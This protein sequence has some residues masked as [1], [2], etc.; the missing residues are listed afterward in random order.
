MSEGIYDI[1]KLL[2]RFPDYRD[3]FIV[4]AFGQRDSYASFSVTTYPLRSPHIHWLVLHSSGDV[5][6]DIAQSEAVVQ[7]LQ[8]LAGP[9]QVTPCF[10]KL[11]AGHNEILR[12]DVFVETVRDFI[13][14]LSNDW[15]GLLYKVVWMY[16]TQE[17]FS[18]SMP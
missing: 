13:V 6:V 2:S 15:H 3:W 16:I 10:D 14:S 17:S 5:L 8:R 4:N 7:H 18:Q 1:D 11:K 12:T 9:A